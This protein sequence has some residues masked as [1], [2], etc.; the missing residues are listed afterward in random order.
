MNSK[1]FSIIF[2]MIWLCI[3]FFTTAMGLSPIPTGSIFI[4]G[5]NKNEPNSKIGIYQIKF[6]VDTISSIPVSEPEESISRL[7]K[8]ANRNSSIILSSRLNRAKSPVEN[9]LEFSRYNTKEKSN[10]ALDLSIDQ[11][12][13]SPIELSPDGAKLV[14]SLPTE[15]KQDRNSDIYIYNIEEKKQIKITLDNSHNINPSWSPDGKKIAYYSMASTN[16]NLDIFPPNTPGFSLKVIDTDGKYLKE[17]APPGYMITF[18]FGEVPQWNPQGTKLLFM[19]KY[20][21]EGPKSIYCV[22]ADGTSLKLIK[23]KGYN[24]RWSPDGSR[25]LYIVDS[26]REANLFTVK[27]EGTG[28]QRM[29]GVGYFPQWS[30]DGEYILFTANGKIK[31]RSGYSLFVI[32]SNGLD[33]QIY[34]IAPNIGINLP[35]EINWLEN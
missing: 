19:A 22:N 11:N 5:Y 13:N 4:R 20:N 1:F 35:E 16:F 17:I 25:I 26:T 15:G 10:K 30:P 9:K 32:K 8:N 28:E 23:T 14:F 27:S 7:I 12:I 31:N 2:S 3:S 18:Y 33:P 24:P 34:D 6:S 21:L 29:P